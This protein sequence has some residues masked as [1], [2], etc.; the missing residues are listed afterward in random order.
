MSKKFIKKTLY[1]S[2]GR[3]LRAG[4]KPFTERPAED[5]IEAKRDN[6]IGAADLFSLFTADIIREEVVFTR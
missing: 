3:R 2:I 1:S 5:R 6:R 4:M